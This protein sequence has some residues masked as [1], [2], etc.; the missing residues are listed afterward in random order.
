VTAVKAFG[1]LPDSVFMW[2]STQATGDYHCEM[3]E[4]NYDKS[5]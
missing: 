3:N 4:N 5:I 2:K 1:F